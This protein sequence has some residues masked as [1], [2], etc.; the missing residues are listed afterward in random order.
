MEFQG[1]LLVGIGRNLRLF[2]LGKKKLLKKCEN[3]LF[4]TAIVRLTCMGDRIFV[5]GLFWITSSIR[6]LTFTWCNRYLWNLD[7][8]ESVLFVK[9]RRHENVLSIFADDSSPRLGLCPHI[10]VLIFIHTYIHTQIK[11]DR[12]NHPYITYIY[13]HIYTYIHTCKHT[14]IH[15]YMHALINTDR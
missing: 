9:Y 4:P 11:K 1:R 14:Y 6:I 15:T 10:K 8:A 12:F 7:L 13:I 5:G 2:D 3:K